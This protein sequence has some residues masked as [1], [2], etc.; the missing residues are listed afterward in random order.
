MTPT[1]GGAGLKGTVAERI[2]SLRERSGLEPIEAVAPVY[3]KILDD[4]SD[5][6][7]TNDVL[8]EEDHVEPD[9]QLGATEPVQQTHAMETTKGCAAPV[10]DMA[11]IGL[12]SLVSPL[13]VDVQ[14]V[15]LRSSTDPQS[16]E[17]KK[18]SECHGYE[19]SASI[20]QSVRDL[21]QKH[22]WNLPTILVGAGFGA[23]HGH[24]KKDGIKTTAGYAALGAAFPFL[25]LGYLAYNKFY[26]KGK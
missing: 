2:N 18:H 17:N 7:P 15:L 25:F 22:P 10:H 16:S 11:G 21:M 13:I 4:A 6:A 24:A 3:G 26:G 1:F 19:Q 5:E 23:Y 20:G 9:Y 14:Y 12:W 8:Y